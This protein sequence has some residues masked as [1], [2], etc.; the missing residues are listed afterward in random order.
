[1]FDAVDRF[2][3]VVGRVL[4]KISAVAIILMMISII[5]QVAASRA[6]VTTVLHMPS[7]WP[8][9]GRA[10]TLN[11]LT[12][13][14]WY[15]LAAVALLPAGVVWLRGVHVRVDFAYSRF[16]PR[17]KALVDLA[18]LLIFALPFLVLVIPEAWSATVTSFNRGEASPNSGLTDRFLARG[19]MPIGLGLLLAALLFEA[20][21]L[22][23]SWGRAD[24]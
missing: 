11:A 10:V 13:L 17:G 5:V 23:K 1:M 6:G 20:W 2:A 18:G 16:G 12:D 24:G 19:T 8:L 7:D 15:L 9:F 3:T 4:I 14:Q 22:I 21:V